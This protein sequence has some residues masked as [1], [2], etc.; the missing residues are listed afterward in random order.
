MINIED[1]IPEL[2][3]GETL[4]VVIFQFRFSWGF[5]YSFFCQLL[6]LFLYILSSV[7]MHR[8]INVEE[9]FVPELPEGEAL[10]AVQVNAGA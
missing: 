10:F 3:K 7:L 5:L 1:F 8:M 2:P 9:D 4:M 6:S